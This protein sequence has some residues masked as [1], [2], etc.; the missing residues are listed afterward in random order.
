MSQTLLPEIPRLP[1]GKTLT[2]KDFVSDNDVRWC[3]GCGDYAVLNAV[4]KTLPELGI[5]KENFVFVSGIGC[6]SRFPYYMA[7]YGF[8][9]IHGRAPT[10]ATGLKISRPDLS[11]W[12]VTGDGDGL[13]I[14]GNH[15]MH[16]LRR[17]VDLKVL[18]FN[19]RIYGL[20]KGQYSPTSESGKVTKSSPYGTLDPALRPVRLAL[21]SGATFVA[22]CLDVDMPGMCAMIKRA[23]EHKGAAFIEIYQNCVVF[24]DGAFDSVADKERRPD[25]ALYLEHGRPMIFGRNRE[26][27]IVLDGLKLKTVTIGEDGITE[28]D[29]LVHNENDPN[30]AALLGE[31]IDPFDP[32]PLGVIKQEPGIPS[33]E[34][35][36]WQQEQAAKERMGAPNLAKLYAA[37]DSWTVKPG[38][39]QS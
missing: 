25:N 19:N 39:T 32:L 38:T 24:N 36:N 37:G 17:N 14:G 12:L 30:L 2:K 33:Y 34:T 23:A 28:A 18:L 6:S 9:T 5:P 7:T 22:R 4:Q 3:P 31:L 13:S 10:F 35:L 26:K 21:A 15:L 16:T 11:V 20:T 29:L 1:E 8:H 27:G